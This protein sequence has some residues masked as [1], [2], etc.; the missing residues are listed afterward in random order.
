MVK[1]TTYFLLR[2]LEHWLRST[3]KIK[4]LIWDGEVN[5]IS[6]AVFSS[7]ITNYMY[8]PGANAAANTSD[9]IIFT[10]K[11]LYLLYDVK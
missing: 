2:D 4:L 8:I 3:K 5:F 10:A 7:D 6:L 1:D 9:I 11:S